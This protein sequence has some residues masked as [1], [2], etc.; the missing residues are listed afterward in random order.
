MDV[1]LQA[2]QIKLANKHPL[3]K[4]IQRNGGLGLGLVMPFPSCYSLAA[5]RFLRDSSYK[6]P[7]S[8]KQVRNYCR[9]ATHAVRT[10]LNLRNFEGKGAGLPGT[11]HQVMDSAHICWGQDETRRRRTFFANSG[12]DACTSISE[13][14]PERMCVC[15]RA[16]LCAVDACAH[17][18]DIHFTRLASHQSRA[19]SFFTELSHYNDSCPPGANVE[20][21]APRGQGHL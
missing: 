8:W 9:G 3:A 19:A 11:N 15:A 21:Q 1:K 7:L 17:T 16:F 4:K 10:V 6:P 14:V 13:H 18:L 12:I 2:A 20:G 5:K